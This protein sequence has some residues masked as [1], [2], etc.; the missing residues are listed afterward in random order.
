MWMVVCLMLLRGGINRSTRR[1]ESGATFGNEEDRP[2]PSAFSCAR[3]ACL[4]DL[5]FLSLEGMFS[6]A[7]INVLDELQQQHQMLETCRDIFTT[8]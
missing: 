1:R 8:S 4:T 3:T 2:Q 6:S 7:A 5:F